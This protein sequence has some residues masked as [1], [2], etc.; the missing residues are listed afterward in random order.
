L[1]GDVGRNGVVQADRQAVDQ[2]QVLNDRAA[3]DAP[4]DSS[5]VRDL[6]TKGEHFAEPAASPIS[7]HTSPSPEPRY[8]LDA[9][10]SLE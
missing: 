5:F 3:S 7:C 1:F 4:F 8:S 9:K 10:N 2:V 6:M